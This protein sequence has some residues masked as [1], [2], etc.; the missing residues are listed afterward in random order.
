MYNY[1]VF[2]MVCFMRR[3]VLFI[4]GGANLGIDRILGGALGGGVGGHKSFKNHWGSWPLLT[5]C[6]YAYA[7]EGHMVE[8][9]LGLT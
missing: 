6:S 7:I 3:K 8:Q 5:P 2:Y 9:S 1:I 4:E